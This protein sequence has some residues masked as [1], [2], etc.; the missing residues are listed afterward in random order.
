MVDKALGILIRVVSTAAWIIG[1][2]IAIL[3][4]LL[5]LLA[6]SLGKGLLEIIA[7]INLPLTS[8]KTNNLN[9]T[10]QQINLYQVRIYQFKRRKRQFYKIMNLSKK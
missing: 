4:I 10:K 2:K 5:I 1:L 6:I 8:I 9:L 3:D 7:I